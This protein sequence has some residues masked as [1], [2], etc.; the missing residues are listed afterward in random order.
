MRLLS[1]II[2]LCFLPYLS[3]AQADS[4]SIN[5]E[6]VVIAIKVPIKV[7][8]DT[9]SYTVDSFSKNKNSSTEE[10]LKRL[11]G[12][13]VDLN[14][15]ITVQ[16]KPVTRLFINGKEYATVD[17]RTITQNLPA[18]VLEKIQVSDWHSENEQFNGIK[19][20]PGE[21]ML[22]LQF[23]QKY[24]QGLFSKSSAGYGSKNRY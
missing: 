13:D 15:K 11:P 5:L 1:V 6:E 14:G 22:N 7:S 23:K 8:A 20:E 12:I 4:N 17:L 19:K 3:K 24:K 9:V 10:V 16:G 18:E 21:K 2:L